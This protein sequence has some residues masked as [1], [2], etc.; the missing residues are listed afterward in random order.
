MFGSEGKIKMKPR[1]RWLG[2]A[3][4]SV[5]VLFARNDVIA[6]AVTSADSVT[7]ASCSAPAYRQ[8][9]FWAG[10]W[11][12]FDV[13]SPIKVAHARVDLILDGC[14][15][16]EDYQGA[17]GHKG[18]SFTI[19]DTARKVW[20]QS[21]V[22]NHGELLVIEGKPED[23]KMV[24][25]GEDHAAGTVVRG[26]WKPENGGVRETAVI[27]ADGGK[28]WKPWFDLEFR[29]SSN[30][31]DVASSSSANVRINDRRDDKKD[32]KK[33][34]AALDIRYQAA[35]QQSDADAMDRILADDFV[36]VTGSGKLFTKADLLAEARD[37]HLHYERQEDTDQTVRVWGDTAVVTA[38]LFA[39][40]AD[41]GTPFEYAVW[42]SDTYVRTPA[43]WR[44]VFGQSSLRLPKAP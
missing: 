34:V 26:D 9:D 33:I 19:Y 21:W 27:S 1:V 24:L 32:D 29:P 18:Q 22:T 37:G 15:L 16:R 38:K 14:V 35:V 7:A 43:G 12:V 5:I 40:G 2:A 41:D 4:V 31:A 42:F 17:D 28:T 30:A 8:F 44:Y 11:N 25:S 10:D 3:I 6:G 23:G 13:G 20:H 36:L 39:K